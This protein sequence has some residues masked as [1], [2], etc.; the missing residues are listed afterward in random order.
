MQSR[1]ALLVV[2]IS[3]IVE[4]KIEY[5]KTKSSIGCI[6]T[7]LNPYIYTNMIDNK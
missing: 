3:Q 7:A 1:Q 5:V 4:E 2:K 6:S